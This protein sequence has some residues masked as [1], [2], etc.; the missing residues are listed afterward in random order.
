ML[1]KNR[2]GEEVF[3]LNKKGAG[4]KMF[5]LSSLGRRSSIL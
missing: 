1:N 4:E 5:N 2:A 3:K